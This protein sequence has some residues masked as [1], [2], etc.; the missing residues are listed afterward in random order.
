MLLNCAEM[1]LIH[2]CEGGGGKGVLLGVVLPS[3]F[4]FV[5]P[6]LISVCLGAE[7]CGGSADEVMILKVGSITWHQ[8]I[9][10]ARPGGGLFLSAVPRGQP[11]PNAMQCSA[12]SYLQI[13]SSTLNSLCFIHSYSQKINTHKQMELEPYYKCEYTYEYTYATTW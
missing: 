4:C 1:T 5:Y 12:D 11:Y 13:S 9:S 6:E 2:G 8:D 3:L 7:N 10:G